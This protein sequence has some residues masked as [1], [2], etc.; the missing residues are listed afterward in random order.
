MSAT[1]RE[2]KMELLGPIESREWGQNAASPG[3]ATME[4]IT[5]H[6]INKWDSKANESLLQKSYGENA[7]PLW[8]IQLVSWLRLA[9]C[10]HWFLETSCLPS[11]Q[12][13]PYDNPRGCRAQWKQNPWCGRICRL[14]PLSVFVMMDCLLL[15]SFWF[16]I[17]MMLFWTCRSKT[18]TQDHSSRTGVPNW[19]ISSFQALKVLYS[20]NMY[21]FLLH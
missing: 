16:K 17:H 2:I 19:I 18:A 6:F 5:R 14:Q 1:E 9:P 7:F 13:L 15:Y 12:L 11:L 21:R 4:V 20:E 10:S 3:P 8:W